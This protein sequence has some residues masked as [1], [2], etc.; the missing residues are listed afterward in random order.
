MDPSPRD[1]W[2]LAQSEHFLDAYGKDRRAPD[3]VAQGDATAAWP[4]P[5]PRCL[6]RGCSVPGV[7]QSP[8][9]CLKPVGLP[10]VVEGAVAVTEP[11]QYLTQLLLLEGGKLQLR[12]PLA[13][14][15]NTLQEV[16]SR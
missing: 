9:Q 7:G 12:Y 1:P 6:A 14:T 8:L 3:F 5:S 11:C 2:R 10:Q 16:R 4:G 13:Q 15:A